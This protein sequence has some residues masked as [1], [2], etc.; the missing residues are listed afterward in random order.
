MLQRIDLVCLELILE[1][2]IQGILVGC[3][4]MRALKCCPYLLDGDAGIFDDVN[5]SHLVQ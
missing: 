3:R 2:S 5:V 1:W 4:L